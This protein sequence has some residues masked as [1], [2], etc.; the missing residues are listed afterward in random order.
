MDYHSK[1]KV[2]EF[3]EIVSYKRPDGIIEKTSYRAKILKVN[4]LPYINYLI[5]DLYTPSPP[6]WVMEQSIRELTEEE[7][8]YHLQARD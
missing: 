7:E 8:A 1:Y 4:Y 5:K 6:I 2:G 3:V